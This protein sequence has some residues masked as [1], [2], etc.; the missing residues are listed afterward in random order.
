[1]ASTRNPPW[2]PIENREIV[3]AYL[4]MLESELRGEDVN[5][6]TRYRALAARVERGEKAIERKFQNVSAVLDLLGLPWIQG[7]KPAR[8]I[9]VSLTEHV[10]EKLSDQALLSRLSCAFDTDRRNTGTFEYVDAPQGTSSAPRDET[11]TRLA[12]KFDPALRDLRARELGVA[13]EALVVNREKAW[14]TAQGKPKLAAQVRWIAREDGDGAGFDILSFN[15]NGKDRWL[16]V[17][18]TNGGDTTPFY[19]TRNEL[20]VSEAN[21]DRYR[22]VRLFDFARVPRA[23]RLSPPLAD[24]LVLDPVS[25]RASLRSPVT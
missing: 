6:S 10:E 4:D 17:K 19:L 21:L 12:R 23:Y 8:N 18:T 9:Q 13:G 25:Y 20:F 22:I 16:E 14:L 11:Q 1:M 2:S 15:L 7:L 5:K 24:R 3:Q